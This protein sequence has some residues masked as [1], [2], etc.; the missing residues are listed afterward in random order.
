MN[1]QD[2][3]RSLARWRAWEARVASRWPEGSPLANLARRRA[4][5]AEL[6]LLEFQEAE[7]W[8]PEAPLDP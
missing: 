3:R 2:L 6:R 7:R 4:L 8:T 5:E 1:E